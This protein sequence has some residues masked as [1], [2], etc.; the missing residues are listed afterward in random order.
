L[1]VPLG[2]RYTRIRVLISDVMS[3]GVWQLQRAARDWGLEMSR[4]SGR[5]KAGAGAGAGAVGSGSGSGSGSGVG[6]ERERK[7][8]LV[9]GGGQRGGAR[10]GRRGRGRAGRESQFFLGAGY[11]F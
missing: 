3:G 1:D 8:N 11:R 7:A 10:G 2:V 9:G 4:G 6:R 5:R